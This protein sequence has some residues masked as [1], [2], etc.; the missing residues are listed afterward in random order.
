MISA[1]RIASATIKP[2]ANGILGT[3]RLREALDEL[4]SIFAGDWI[5]RT[6]APVYCCKESCVR[7]ETDN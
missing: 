6:I 1:T 7:R 5:Q 3:L 4:A 2:K